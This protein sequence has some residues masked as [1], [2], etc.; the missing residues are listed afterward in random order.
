MTQIF[1]NTVYTSVKQYNKDMKASKKD[2]FGIY[3]TIFQT[4]HK[5]LRII[6]WK[7]LTLS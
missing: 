3:I 7:K 6:E 5:L 4:W 1:G 2:L